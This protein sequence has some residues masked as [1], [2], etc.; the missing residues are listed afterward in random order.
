MKIFKIPIYSPPRCYQENRVEE[1]LSLDP[2]PVCLRRSGSSDVWNPWKEKKKKKE[3]KK[4]FTNRRGGWL[5]D[6]EWPRVR[7][8]VDRGRLRARA[9]VILRRSEKL[10]VENSKRSFEK[11]VEIRTGAIC[12]FFWT[13]RWW[14]EV[15]GGKIDGRATRSKIRPAEPRG[16]NRSEQKGN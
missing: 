12:S 9:R 7:A 2:L 11:I 4:T 13:E 14:R 5:V 1:E 8:R 15:E 3:R 6:E 16:F 10:A